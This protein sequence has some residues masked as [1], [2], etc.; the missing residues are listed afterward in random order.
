MITLILS[1]VFRFIVINTKL[2]LNTIMI[3]WFSKCWGGMG[4]ATEFERARK[5]TTYADWTLPDVEALN[6][7]QSKI[8][9]CTFHIQRR[10]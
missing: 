7:N 5:I 4:V 9:S 8:H 10:E 2:A 3:G 1:V 6:S